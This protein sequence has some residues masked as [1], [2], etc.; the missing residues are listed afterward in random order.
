MSNNDWKEIIINTTVVVGELLS[1]F[2]LENGAKGVVLGEWEPEKVS[3]YTK[4]KAYFPFDFDKDSELEE[5]IQ[6]LF[7]TYIDSGLNT[8]AK[9]ITFN[10]V[11]EEDW[12]NSWKQYFHTLKIGNHTIIKP[13]WETYEK[14]E[15]EI[16]INFDPGMAFGTGSHPSTKLCMEE[17]E[18][19]FFHNNEIDKK[20]YNI[21]DLGTGSG[22]LS[23]QLALMG[24][25]KITA[26][27]NDIVAVKA[28]EEN[29][30][31]ND[32]SIKLL[33]GSTNVC[34]D[35]YDF[36]AGNILAEII[37]MLSED[38]SKKL[39]K[40]GLFMGSGIIN[41]KRQDVINKLT[42]L[43]LE[44]IKETNDKDWVMLLFK[45]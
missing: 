17:L 41:H 27:D 39:K 29:F 21:L 13:L 3:E 33:H 26:V 2:L 10:T 30:K 42:S 11:K 5:K 31:L 23:I 40:G 4:V 1:E 20:N 38:I 14:K 15:T 22:I 36:I 24:F 12:A 9:E 43:G 8:G 18:E 32:L 44:L 37:E 45:K 28:S 19:R 7:K 16:V 34:S 6:D 35:E 25:E